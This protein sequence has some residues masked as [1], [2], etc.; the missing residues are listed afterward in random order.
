[1][2][3][4]VGAGHGF[5]RDMFEGG[6]QFNEGPLVHCRASHQ[7]DCGKRGSIRADGVDG[8]DRVGEADEAVGVD[9]AGGA[10]GLVMV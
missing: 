3:M 10:A 8:V 4:V 6:S 9:G 7:G 2:Q 1:M 5:E